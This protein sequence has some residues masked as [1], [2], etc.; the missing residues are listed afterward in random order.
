MYQRF[1]M[2]TKVI[3][4]RNCIIQNRELLKNM[5]KKALIVTGRNSARQN[6]SLK[7]VVSAL[8]T[9]GI[10][11]VIYDRIEN[12]PSVESAYE[13]ALFAKC[14]MIDF[15][16][17]I[18]GGSPMD[19]GKAIALLSAQKI[20][21]S[22]LF[23]G[24]YKNRIMPLVLVP[25]TSGT[26]S[27]VT[28]YA[29]LTNDAAQT[30]TSIATDMIFPSIAFLDPTY[31]RNLSME[32]T[33]NTAVDA[34]SHSIEGMLSRKSSYISNAI[35]KESIKM[36]SECMPEL[37]SAK[38]NH[39]SSMVNAEIREKLMIASF[40]AGVVIAQTGTTAGHALGYSLTYFKDI[41][42][43]RANGLI[44]VE[45][46]KKIEETRP[47]LIKDILNSA[48]IKNL[49]ELKDLLNALLG[50]GEQLEA[51]EIEKFSQIAMQTKNIA[52]CLV[53]FN[54]KQLCDIYK[55]S[56]VIFQ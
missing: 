19:A 55:K 26:G 43:G 4:G 25:T 14:T 49:K 2:P 46:L 8:E 42:H 33:I 44:M 39:D 3:S 32:T 41:D 53:E 50:A 9:S 56:F 17:A 52:N 36:I 30:K 6:G 16:I 48:N 20:D 54:E 11:Y 28:P 37:K 10:E 24:N 13:G 1:Y 31:S 40:M 45:F 7:D 34:L 18:G 51:I 35:A 22:D 47:D 23:L 21:R 38:S 15:V 5:G 29:I 12:N 27:E